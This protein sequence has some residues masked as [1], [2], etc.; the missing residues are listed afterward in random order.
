[1]G[2][3]KIHSAAR[4]RRA[5]MLP[6][7]C[8]LK[9]L[10]TMARKSPGPRCSTRRTDTWTS[11]LDPA[12][13]ISVAVIT[14]ERNV[15][16]HNYLLRRRQIGSPRPGFRGF[17]CHGFFRRF[18][19]PPEPLSMACRRA[20]ARPEPAS[21]TGGVT[22]FVVAGFPSRIRVFPFPTT[23]RITT[24]NRCTKPDPPG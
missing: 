11:L 1:M 16:I 22:I 14:F 19:P 10:A 6:G 9:S 7:C 2:E 21:E 13:A 24:R 8:S 18:R 12:S 23:G 20:G 15:R 4:C 5:A 3:G 17:P